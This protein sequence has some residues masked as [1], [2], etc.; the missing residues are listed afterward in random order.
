MIVSA[1]GRG[2]GVPAA[3]AHPHAPPTVQPGAEEVCHPGSLLLGLG[4]ELPVPR[5]DAVLLHGQG[6]L[7]LPSWS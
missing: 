1:H 6:P 2:E 5:L 3:H 7:H 4:G